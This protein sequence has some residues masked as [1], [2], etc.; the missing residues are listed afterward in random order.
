MRL[1]RAEVVLGRRVGRAHRLRCDEDPQALLSFVMVAAWLFES[2]PAPSEV[3]RVVRRLAHLRL[4]LHWH[5]K[6]PK[7][8][9]GHR[10]LQALLAEPQGGV[11]VPW[12]HGRWA[13]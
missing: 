5:P 7:A 4:D 11:S 12:G 3:E 9:E 1:G 8:L 10:Q 6:D 2:P 13:I